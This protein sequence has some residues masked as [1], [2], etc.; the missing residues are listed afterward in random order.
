MKSSLS[1]FP[2]PFSASRGTFEIQK[3]QK[4]QRKFLA[5]GKILQVLYCTILNTVLYNTEHCIVQ[6]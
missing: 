5:T 4:K 3:K 1:S 2:H 6:Y